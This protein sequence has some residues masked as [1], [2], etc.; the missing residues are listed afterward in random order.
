[1]FGSAVPCFAFSQSTLNVKAF[2][3]GYYIDTP[4]VMHAVIDPVS[5]PALFDTITVELHNVADTVT[6]FSENVVFNING[7]GTVTLPPAVFGNYYYLAVKH[8]NSIQTWSKLP[9]LITAVTDYD[10]TTSVTTAFGNNLKWVT[11]AACIYSGDINQDGQVD[12]N[13]M[14]IIDS[15]SQ[16]FTY[17]YYNSA[18]I[19]GDSAVDALD[20][21]IA[22]A[23][24]NGSVISIT[25]SVTSVNGNSSSTIGFYPN[26]AGD[27]LFLKCESRF[28]RINIY[29]MTGALKLFFDDQS[30][31]NLQSLQSGSYVISC[32]A[33]GQSVQF[34]MIKL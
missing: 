31:L 4:G 22:D 23:N 34:N 13:D 17:E 12:L 5:Q 11:N 21:I 30:L 25:P 10:F 26:P 8:R 14:S 2:V 20:M 29:D 19:N 1:M 9:V 28:E 3:E 24:I 6:E 16:L 18:D 7:Q 15:L 32:Q 33:A 27:F